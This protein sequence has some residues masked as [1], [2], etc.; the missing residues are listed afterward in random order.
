MIQINIPYKKDNH[1]PT[2]WG[3][4]KEHL[5]GGKGIKVLFTPLNQGLHTPSS[6]WDLS[7]EKIFQSNEAL[8]NHLGYSKDIFILNATR[9]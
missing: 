9:Y 7:Y 8:N 3:Y 6:E 1:T 4:T 5:E 2:Y